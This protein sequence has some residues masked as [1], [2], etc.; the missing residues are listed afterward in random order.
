MKSKITFL[1]ILYSFLYANAQVEFEDHTVI[2]N[3]LY[4]QSPNGVYS[5]DFDGDGDKDVLTSSYFGNR[6][7]WFENLDGTGGDFTLHTITDAIPTP[8][9]V[10]AADLDGDGDMDAVSASLSG[11]NVAWYENTDG[12][13]T[14]VLKQAR[15]AYK[16]NFVMAADVDNDNDLDL[17]W[18]S[19]SE[20]EMGWFKNTDGLG[21]FNGSLNI[22]NN[23][24]SIPGFYPADING[25]G[26]VDIVS[27]YS[28]DGGGS[29]GVVWYPKT[30]T[31]SF[32]NRTL[33]SN[34]VS[35]VTSV[36]A[37]DIDGDG[38]VDVVSASGSDDK[39]AWY[40][41]T[42]GLGTFGTQQVL[43]VTAVSASVVRLADMD[44][45]GDLDIIFGSNE[46]KKIGWFQNTDGQGNFSS[47]TLIASHSGDIRDICFS[48]M[49]ADGDL[50]FLTATN[51]DNNIKLYKNTFGTGTYTPS[52]IT[53]FIDGGRVVRADDI[54]GDGDK[55]IIGASYW[56]S[57]IS[58]FENKDGQGDFHNTQ[59]VV[60][61]TMHG[62]SAV[63][64]GDLNGDGFTDILATSYLDNS[65]MW[66][67]NTDGLGTFASPQ[68]I[69]NDL[70]TAL[71]V[72]TADIDDDGD[73][74][75]IASGHGKIK[76]YKNVDGLGS[77]GTPIVIDAMGN[78]NTYD[79]DFGDLDG[80]GDLDMAAGFSYGVFYYRNLDGQGTYSARQP[81]A[82]YQYATYSVKIADFN[83]DGDNDIVFTG[84]NTN[85]SDAPY[86][87]WSENNGSGTFGGNHLI[88]TLIATPK[89]IIA[90]DIDNDG[91][92]DVASA[93]AG[94]GG[95][96]AW[97]SNT[98][99]Q[100]NFE[101][102]QQIISQ[103][104]N[105]PN[106]LFAADIDGNDTL[107]IV[108]TSEYDDKVV[109]HKNIP[110][111]TSNS[112]GGM[113]RF[114]FQ[115]DGCNDTDAVLSGILVV[116]SDDAGTN[117]T[118]SQENGHFQLY[119]TEEGMVTTKITSQLPD[120]YEPNPATFESNF[121][122][123][124]NHDDVNFCIVPTVVINDLNV[125]FY[126]T[127]NAPRP[128]FNTAYRIVYKNTGTT[129][130]NGAVTFGYDGS[131][132][133]F[134]NASEA[135][136]SQTS[137]T[138]VF[139]FTDLNPFETKTIE[140]Y[141]NV[142]APPVTNIGDVLTTTATIS[143]VAG[144]N[145]AGDN[146]FSCTQTVVGSYDPNDISCL[147][148][149]EVLI[150]DAGKYLHYLVRFQN[151]GTASAIN[152]RVAQTLDDKLDWTTMQLE[153][154]SHPGRVDIHNGSEVSFVFDD[155]N[156][157]DSTSDEAHSHG[158]IAYKI[159]PKSNVA[160]GDTVNAAA[161]IYFDFNP[162]VV[163]NTATT[164]FVDVLSVDGSEAANI[165]LSPNPT[166]GILN[167][168]ATTKIT[169]AD[170]YNH[171][172]Q[173]VFSAKDPLKI[174]ISSLSQ[175]IYVMTLKDVSG[176]TYTRKIIRK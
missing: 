24:T 69:D 121:T 170:L 39:I 53:K 127:A 49:D 159:K 165:T 89:N 137:N 66:F 68:I 17:I 105:S 15:Y 131:K 46:D 44:G 20:G 96:L 11:N 162:P 124:G 113:V 50:D 86:L 112:I 128:G 54:D 29:Q 64:T 87:R 135:V 134:L 74:D 94:N 70:Y 148:G 9:A 61:D 26:A 142:S 55:D 97:Y 118:F 81:I 13:G 174:D 63:C 123:L 73:L 83:N 3:A 91:D 30:G 122:G 14:F 99:G 149:N 93:D 60:S 114:D 56:D 8:W 103:G 140:L 152:V 117:A 84:Q 4:V 136:T 90:A 72:F 28:I 2:D 22:E 65:V 130:L 78:S 104:L 62:A 102:T 98:D 27:A 163:T 37:G 141:F 10:Y 147:E 107:D 125:S 19:R 57:K 43:S 38:D 167:I 18:S 36:Y 151:T 5:A 132:L 32:G 31:S 77:F 25:D 154:L 145:T 138:L 143:P 79:I 95:V 106:Y 110:L 76:L 161:G 173:L 164:E 7:V 172:G 169:N 82:G 150:A 75:V 129:Q 111:P 139:D 116:A 156:L 71:N 35:Y 47:E 144:D 176:N 88:T 52:I 133:N 6:L 92:T 155:I 12:H 168:A 108:S 126:P 45:D 59:R 42:D 48:D 166:D 1:A 146:V 100:G 120:Y 85:V 157:P 80:D 115:A 101:N 175:G 67:K 33:I 109:W 171:L 160:T 21:D 23:V 51:I 16:A 40:E 119:T 158:F 34:A 41:N 153:S 58:W